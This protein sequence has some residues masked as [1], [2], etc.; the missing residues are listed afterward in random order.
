M[1]LESLR[2]EVWKYNLLLPK[3]GLVVM[4]SGNIS[5]RDPRPGWW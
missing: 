1:H 5:G 4:T 2:N 3:Y